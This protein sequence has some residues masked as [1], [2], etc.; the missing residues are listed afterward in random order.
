MSDLNQ[1]ENQ[2]AE[3]HDNAGDGAPLAGNSQVVVVGLVI[4]GSSRSLLRE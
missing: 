3:E 2:K 1:D 4:S